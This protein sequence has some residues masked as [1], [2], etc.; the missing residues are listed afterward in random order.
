MS[1]KVEIKNLTDRSKLYREYWKLMNE[2]EKETK[3]ESLPFTIEIFKPK[4]YAKKM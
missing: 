1:K 2:F 3:T 4:I